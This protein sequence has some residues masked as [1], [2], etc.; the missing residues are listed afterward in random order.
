MVVLAPLLEVSG[1]LVALG[2]ITLAV[3]L[4]AALFK[5]AEATV[6]WI[7]WLGTKA[8]GGLEA[9]RKRLVNH[10]S[11]WVVGIEGQIADSWHML[12]GLI[13]QTGDAI[14]DVSRGVAHLYWYVEFKLP[15][16]MAQIAARAAHGTT[17][18][19]TKHTTT[20]VRRV[21]VVQGVTAKQ[22]RDV[23]RRVAALSVIVAAIRA[24]QAH[25]PALPGIHVPSLPISLKGI[26]A[27][28]GK[29]ER[30]NT[31]KGAA[32]FVAAALATLG[33][34]WTRRSC[35]K[36]NNDLLCKTDF[37]A[38]EALLGGAMIAL[39]F[40]SVVKFADGMLAAEEE[41]VSVLERMI[42]ELGDVAG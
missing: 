29:L 35:T 15:A 19:I 27:R 38:L 8:K 25:A 12:A 39:N 23:S 4:V 37:G 26:R 6:G 17:S 30:I 34:S 24:A 14:W 20:V 40:N 41:M 1:L 5:T 36:R 2:L 9:T 7:P 31:R 13:E 16:L 21:T 32:A 18:T 33:L 28:L 11:L 22:L 3:V 10:M 42:V